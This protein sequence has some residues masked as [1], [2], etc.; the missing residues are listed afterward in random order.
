MYGGP[1][2]VPKDVESTFSIGRERTGNQSAGETCSAD[3]Y[4]G[5]EMCSVPLSVMAAA[6][7]GCSPISI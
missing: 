3:W 5:N 6:V 7:T 4:S 1:I 2:L